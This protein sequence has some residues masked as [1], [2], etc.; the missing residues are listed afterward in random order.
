VRRGQFVQKING[1]KAS[2]EL[3]N[4]T[5]AAAKPG[6]KINLQITSNDQ[7]KNIDIILEKKKD[8]PFL[9]ATIGD[10]DPLQKQI[11]DSWLKG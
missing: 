5:L 7:T 11:L 3:L 1:E 9:I 8:R 2:N 4:K 6:D 10:P